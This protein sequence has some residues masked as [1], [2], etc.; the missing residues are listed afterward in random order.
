M[1]IIFVPYITT[2]NGIDQMYLIILYTVNVEYINVCL[3]YYFHSQLLKGFK[4][5]LKAFW[6]TT[7]VS[8]TKKCILMD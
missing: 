7:S 4:I 3:P 5:F 2:S 6:L 1:Q 8:Y